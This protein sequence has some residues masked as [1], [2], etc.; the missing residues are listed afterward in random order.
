MGPLLNITNSLFCVLKLEENADIDKWKYFGYGI[1]F[2][3]SWIFSLAS[4]FGKNIIIFG[5]D[6]SSSEHVDN[7]KKYI[8]YFLTVL[9]KVK[10]LYNILLVEG[11]TQGLGKNFV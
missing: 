5:A 3:R 4:G 11:P 2:D 1:G 7:K 6:M 8:F 10:V 9:H